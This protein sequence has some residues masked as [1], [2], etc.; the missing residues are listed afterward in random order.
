M[1]WGS[2]GMVRLVANNP[3]GTYALMAADG[4]EAGKD[5]TYQILLRNREGS[6]YLLENMP[7]RF[8]AG[9]PQLDSCTHDPKC[10]SLILDQPSV[11]LEGNYQWGGEHKQ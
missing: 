1:T 5:G 9:V 3:V 8:V 6:Q 4:T 11:N 7:V 2:D 10:L